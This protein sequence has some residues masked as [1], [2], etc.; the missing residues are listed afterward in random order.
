MVWHIWSFFCVTVDGVLLS[1]LANQHSKWVYVTY[2][3]ILILLAACE[4]PFIFILNRIVNEAV[5]S[6]TSD[7]VDELESQDD[8]TNRLLE[9]A[10]AMPLSESSKSMDKSRQSVES[11]NEPLP[12]QDS[13]F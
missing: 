10:L 5:S 8:E 7:Q 6:E 12:E 13:D 2:Y 4:L 3:L 9:E 11:I 1:V